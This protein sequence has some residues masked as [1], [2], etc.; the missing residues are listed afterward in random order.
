MFCS[1]WIAYRFL[2]ST[3]YNMDQRIES[4][5]LVENEKEEKK[6]TSGLVEPKSDNILFSSLVLRAP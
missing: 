2:I 1:K 4:T 5:K 3:F 6:K